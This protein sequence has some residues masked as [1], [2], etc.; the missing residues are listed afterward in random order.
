[1]GKLLPSYK[2]ALYDEMI[3]NISTGN[4]V[5]YAF[6]ANPVP[7]T[8]AVPTVTDDDYSALFTN[9][10][11]MLF[12]KRLSVSNFAPLIR[13]NQWSNNT[14]YD[15]YDNRDTN[16]HSNNN[17][18]VLAPPDRIGGSYHVFTCIDNANGAPSTIK[19]NLVQ[20]T[21]F[22][23]FPDGYKWRYVGSVSYR[24]YSMFST[25]NL[26]PVFANNILSLNAGLYSGIDVV[27]IANNGSG[28]VAYNDGV[29]QS[30]N[31]SVVQ[32]E[33]SAEA[34]NEYY[35]NSAI[36][37]YNTGDDT[38]QLF[39][40][41]KY[42]ANSVGKWVYVDGEI[43]TDTILPASTNY[44]ISPK[45]VFHTD[46][47]TQPLAYSIVNPDNQGIANIVILDTGSY[48][49]W[50]N[51]HVESNFGVGS[52]LYAIVP[53]PGGHGY[54]V[55]SELDIQ[56]FSVAFN[57]SNTENNTIP[58]DALYNKI[59]IV[60]N[61]HVFVANNRSK[62]NV[63]T[64]STFNQ[65]LEITLDDPVQFTA[66]DYVVGNTSNA[67]GTIVFANTSKMYLT[68]DKYFSNGEYIVSSNGSLTAQINV[69]Y[70]GD[71]FS[72]DSRP[73][74]IQNINN[75]ERSNTQTESFQLVIRI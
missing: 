52:D 61:P 69:G 60:K 50:A 29:I 63:Y 53:P 45:V 1:M 22:Q 11:Q 42:V 40:I 27:I 44:K 33:N 4:S 14:I 9:S 57:F 5:Y 26:A 71:V 30:V 59:G 2:K 28:Y 43:N 7:Y 18:Y 32:I 75:V 65:L 48:I 10:W 55:L 47:N 67:V 24:E 6:A 16:L 19:P 64:S 41:T 17:F 21:T 34:Q 68:G 56:G 37:I 13:N 46:G 72:K 62:G 66:G 25:A 20:A 35:T 54:D 12:G 8:G 74:Y 58:T 70:L 3:D 38:A 39:G 31:T 51:V 23:T 73:L 36:Y 15:R 49:T